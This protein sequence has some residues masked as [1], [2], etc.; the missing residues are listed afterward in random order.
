MSIDN[1]ITL[2]VC[3]GLFILAL[4]IMAFSIDIIDRKI[5]EP[6]KKLY[7]KTRPKR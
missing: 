4:V 3:A 7:R 1:Y 2:R 5:I 6:L